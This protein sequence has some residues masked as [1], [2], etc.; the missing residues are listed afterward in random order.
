MSERRCYECEQEHEMS[1]RRCY[2]CEQ[3]DE[4]VELKQQR[5]E[6]KEWNRMLAHHNEQLAQRG[7]DLEQQRDEL[8]V[9]LEQI[10]T[11]PREGDIPQ[12]VARTALAKVKKNG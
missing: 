7:D 12:Q 2:E 1:E 4:I 8:I 3:E 5:D 11:Q 9:A 6:L 10:A